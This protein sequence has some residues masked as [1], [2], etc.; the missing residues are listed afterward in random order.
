MEERIEEECERIRAALIDKENLTPR[1]YDQL[2]AAQQALAWAFD[3]M[4]SPYDMVMGKSIESCTEMPSI[5]ADSVG[6]L[7]PTHQP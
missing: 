5:P 6:C 4:R 3:G 2:Y 7:A 1:Q